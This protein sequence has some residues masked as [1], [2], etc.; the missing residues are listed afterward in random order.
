[1]RFSKSAISALLVAFSSSP[2][3]LSHANAA[4]PKPDTVPESK[5]TKTVRQAASSSTSANLLG[6]LYT[7]ANT[8]DLTA[9]IPAAIPLITALPKIPAGLLSND[10]VTQALSQT[11]RPLSDV[12]AFSITG[13]VGTIYTSFL[14]TWYS[15][16]N[17][18]TARLDSLV[19]RCTSAAGL[20]STARAYETCSQVQAVLSAYSATA[21]DS[22][23]AASS[24]SSTTAATTGTEAATTTT[25]TVASTGTTDSQSAASEMSGFLGGVAGVAAGLLGVAAVL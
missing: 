22:T 25:G 2:F 3:A 7:L 12:C 17:A 21:T 18:N 14:P 23:A 15:W 9:C 20:T 24:S 11:S 19:S 1:M 13:D 6:T 10:V 16:L 4:E 8:F 5:P